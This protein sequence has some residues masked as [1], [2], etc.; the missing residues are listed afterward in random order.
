MFENFGH[1]SF[2]DGLVDIRSTRILSR[3]RRDLMGHR[4]IAP[5]VFVQKDAEKHLDLDDYRL[6]NNAINS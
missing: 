2:K 1:W 6:V 3:R 5:T 4:L